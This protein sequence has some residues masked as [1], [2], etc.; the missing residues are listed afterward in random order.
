MA[1]ITPHPALNP[2]EC[3]LSPNWMRHG[4]SL[5][6]HCPGGGPSF[7]VL[8]KKK[9]YRDVLS[10]RGFLCPC[11][12]ILKSP[13]QSQGLRFG[14]AWLVWKNDTSDQLVSLRGGLNMSQHKVE[15]N[16]KSLS[17]EVFFVGCLGYKM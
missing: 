4:T 15:Q 11:L 14:V 12:H 17:K 3:E 2:Q 5:Y 7:N 8:I 6:Q 16:W 1:L 9:I 13:T 10:S